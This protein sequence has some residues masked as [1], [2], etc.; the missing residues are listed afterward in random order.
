MECAA[1]FDVIAEVLWEIYVDAATIGDLANSPWQLSDRFD[2][3]QRAV[4]ALVEQLAVDA[5]DF[6]DALWGRL[7]S[8][9]DH[10]QLLELTAVITTFVMIG[11]VGDALGVAD[12]VLFSRPPRPKNTAGGQRQAA[13]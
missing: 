13:G 7:R 2:D 1:T 8:H 12:P 11:R 9:W 10:G 3:G 6:S 4:F 5:N